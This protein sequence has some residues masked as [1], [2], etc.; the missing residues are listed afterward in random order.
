MFARRG[1]YRRIKKLDFSRAPHAERKVHI[2]HEGQI[3]KSTEIMKDF[4]SHKNGLIAVERAEGAIVPAFHRFQPA[5]PGMPFIKFPVEGAPDHRRAGIEGRQALEV[6]GGKERIGMVEEQP[7]SVPLLSAE[8]QLPPAIGSASIN[9][10]RPA[11]RHRTHRRR[12]AFG[13]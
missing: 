4:P 8:I 5:Q 6:G 3:S 7:I 11:F 2:L 10:D 9:A 1:P 13:K 12:V